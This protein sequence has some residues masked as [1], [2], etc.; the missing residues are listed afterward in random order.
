MKN[1]VLNELISRWE[2]ES[3][4]NQTE[5]GSDSDDAKIS[6]AKNAAYCECKRECAD[7]LR[8]LMRMLPGE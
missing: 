3:R 8:T 7:A 6:R 2:C 1:A 5:D 4:G